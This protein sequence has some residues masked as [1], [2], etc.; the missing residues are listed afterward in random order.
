[1]PVNEIENLRYED[2]HIRFDVRNSM[3]NVNTSTKGSSESARFTESD[4]NA[5]IDALRARQGEKPHID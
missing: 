5:F 3:I 2:G 4:A 1:M